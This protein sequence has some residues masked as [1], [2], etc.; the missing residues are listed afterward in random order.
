MR[1]LLQIDIGLD[2]E[3]KDWIDDLLKFATFSLVTHLLST[4]TSSTESLFNLEWLK[5]LIYLLI[6]ISAYHL[7][8]KKAITLVYEDDAEE[9]FTKTIRLY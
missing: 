9:G 8:V 1:S 7:V 3:Y 2:K 6:G 4:V 5:G